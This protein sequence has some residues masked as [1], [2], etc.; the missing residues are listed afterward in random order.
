MAKSINL[1]GLDLSSKESIDIIE[2]LTRRRN[3]SNYKR[4]TNEELLSTLKKKPL[5]N[6][7]KAKITNNKLYLKIKKEQKLYEKNL[8]NWAINF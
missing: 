3:V 7:K 8:K 4:M 1:K 2:F 5:K 6:K